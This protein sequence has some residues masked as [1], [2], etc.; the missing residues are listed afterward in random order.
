MDSE[1]KFRKLIIIENKLLPMLRT[2][3]FGEDG[4]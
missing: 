2:N 4:F 1:K 3:K